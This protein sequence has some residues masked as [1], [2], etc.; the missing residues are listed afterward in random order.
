M[1]F[2]NDGCRWF[3]MRDLKP[4]NAKDKAWKTLEGRVKD[5]YTPTRK[6][7]KTVGEKKTL[8]EMPYIND[9]LFV[10]DEYEVVAG[11]TQIIPKLQFRYMRGMPYRTPMCVSDNEMEYF[12]AAAGFSSEPV[13]YAPEELQPWMFGKEVRVIGGPLDGYQGRLLKRRGTSLKRLIV[14]LP[15]ILAIGVDLEPEY[16]QI[17]AE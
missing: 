7:L 6:I 2:N 13:Y 10:R 3:V 16:I 12:K 8:V 11:L 5:I 15:G 4:C 9:L 14:E 1:D 17:V